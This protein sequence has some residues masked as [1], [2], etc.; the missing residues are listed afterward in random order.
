MQAII[1]KAKRIQCL[2]CDLDGVLTDGYLVYQANGDSQKSFHVHDGF[3]LKLLQNSGLE[4]AIITKSNSDLVKKRMQ[5][6]KIEHLYM[7][8]SNKIPAYR[9]LLSK[10]NLSPEQVAYVGD[11]LP[12]LPLIKHSGLGIAVANASEHVKAHA[13][14]ITEK[15]GGHGAV[16]EVCEFIMKAQGT[17]EA[18]LAEYHDTP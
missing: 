17:L 2:I 18:I 11:D 13:D 14:W 15:S 5:D 6:L 8:Q 4:I 9:D 3:G 16:R 12:D 7:N 10:L 1:D